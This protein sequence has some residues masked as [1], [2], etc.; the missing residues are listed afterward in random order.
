MLRKILIVEDD[1]INRMILTDILQDTYEVIASSNGEEGLIELHKNYQQI[2]AIILDLVMP[3]MDGFDFLMNVKDNAIFSQI[4]IFFMASPNSEKDKEKAVV[5]GAHDFISKPYNSFL[6]LNSLKNTI[7]MRENAIMINASQFDRLTGLYN[8]DAFFDKV[9][10][11]IHSSSQE[12][13]LSCMDINNFKYINDQYGSLEG[14]RILK[15]VA[16]VLKKDMSEV[17]GF[18]SR[19]SADN[20]AVIFPKSMINTR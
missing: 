11:L 19:I 7:A 8:H 10:Q 20:F 14:D 9:D 6:I 15:L 18:A 2:S 3:V 5:L 13:I 1:Q 16:N 4:P 12:F 17:D